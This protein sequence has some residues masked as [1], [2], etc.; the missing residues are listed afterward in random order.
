MRSATAYV[1]VPVEI[2]L[3]P[4]PAAEIMPLSLTIAPLRC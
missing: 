4:V 1:L 2:M 3:V